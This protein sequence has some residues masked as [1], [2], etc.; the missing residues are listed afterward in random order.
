M[1]AQM[2]LKFLQ[3]KQDSMTVAEYENK[4]SELSRF[5]PHYVD[6]NAKR[7]RRFQQGLKPWIQNRVAILEIL[8]YAILVQKAQ[9]VERGQICIQRR[10]VEISGKRPFMK[11]EDR[12]PNDKRLEN[13]GNNRFRTNPTA[14][15]IQG[16]PQWPE[17][18]ICGKRHNERCRL[19][20]R[21][22]YTCRKK[23]HISPNCKEKIVNC[24]ACGKKGHYARKC[25]QKNKGDSVPRLE[26]PLAKGNTNN[27]AK[28]NR[29]S[30]NAMPVARTFNMTL[31]DALAYNDV[32]AEPIPLDEIL[33]VEIVNQEVIPVGQVCQGCKIEIQGQPFYVNLI[34]FRLGEFDV[35]LGMDWLARYDAQIN[36]RSKRVSLKGPDNKRIALR[37]QKQ[38]RK[39]LAALQAKRLLRQGC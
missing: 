27:N 36:C 5:V 39:F 14:N 9:I 29:G 31:K 3:L 6:T 2:E 32:I 15:L 37:G 22:S 17:C 38:A 33:A 19:E 8:D 7:T 26:A 30:T 24:Y 12:K 11:R 25:P 34:P 20:E 4:F 35:I 10:R 28:P 18:K 1:E 16:R 21:T 13:K 23:G